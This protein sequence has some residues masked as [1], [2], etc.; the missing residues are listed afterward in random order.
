MTRDD[1]L[2]LTPDALAALANRGLVKRAAKA[3]DAGTVPAVETGED[4]TVR[5]RFDDGVT[6]AL[7]PDAD[8]QEA[9]CSCAASGVCRHRIGL[10]LAYQRQFGRQQTDEASGPFTPWSPGSVDDDALTALYGAPAV[11]AARRALTAGFPARLIRPTPADPVARAELRSCTVRFLVPGEVRYAHTD[12]ADAARH[13]MVVLAVWAFRAADERGLDADDVRLDVGGGPKGSIA[14]PG[15]RPG[16]A[17]VVGLADELLLDGAVHAGAV[18]TAAL[19]RAARELEK[20]GLRWPAA[21]LNELVEQLDAYR[22]RTARHR[23]ERLAELLTE[24]HARHR[25]AVNGGDSPRSRVLGSDEPAETPLRRVHLT[26]LGCRIG[27]GDTG[28]TAELFF[29]HPESGTVLVLRKH[30]PV[31]EDEERPPTGAQLAARRLGGIPLRT[32]ATGQVVTESASRSASRVVRLAAG[33]VARTGVT[34]LGGSQ[35]W[36]RLPASVTAPDL[37]TLERQLS[38]LPPKLIRP[39]VEAELV[40]AVPVAEVHTIGYDPGDQRLDAVIADAAGTTALVT[41]TYDG[42]SPAALDCLAAALAGELGTPRYLSGL[43]HRSGGR[44]T[45]RPLA[46]LTDD[47]PVLPDLAPGDGSTDLD[48]A[49]E[50]GQGPYDPVDDALHTALAACADAAHHGLRHVPPGVRRRLGDAAAALSAVGLHTAAERVTALSKALAEG[51][52]DGMPTAWVEAQLR[53]LTT[54]EL[55]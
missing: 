11:A 25:A 41:A 26:G 39:R 9:S 38:G 52:P 14:A 45:L 32:L 36:R 28:R 50:D 20:Q 46:V 33:R 53:L 43:V 8:L 34:P 4:G 42:A 30:W 15:T 27:G 21:A 17:S 47:G 7:P 44:I 51:D 35:D 22:D 55:R 3:L 6:T 1:L 31:P 49:P 5:G 23:P 37:A 18:A 29:A 16:L 19:R 13:E 2:T 24:L 54:A 40:R 10:V 12:A 48:A